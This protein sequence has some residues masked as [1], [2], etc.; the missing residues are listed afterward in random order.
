MVCGSSMRCSGSLPH[1]KVCGSML[2]G[3]TLGRFSRQ[4]SVGGYAGVLA[5]GGGVVGECGGW[6]LSQLQPSLGFLQVAQALSRLMCLFVSLFLCVPLWCCFCCA[7]SFVLLLCLSLCCCFAHVAPCWLHCSPLVFPCCAASFPFVLLHSFASPVCNPP[8]QQQQ[9][10]CPVVLEPGLGCWLRRVLSRLLVTAVR[11]L[12]CVRTRKPV[13][14][15]TTS[16][17]RT[18]RMQQPACTPSCAQHSCC[19]LHDSAR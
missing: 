12:I 13:G 4:A 14:R 1:S 15:A 17:S 18:P 3:V 8:P 6:R 10:W 5:G 9:P 11:C 19:E 16:R 2:V 7:F